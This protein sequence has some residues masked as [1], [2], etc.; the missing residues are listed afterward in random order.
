MIFSLKKLLILLF[1]LVSEYSLFSQTDTVKTIGV[2]INGTRIAWNY[3]S[4]NNISTKG[5]YVR[6]KRLSNNSLIAVYDDQLG[7]CAFKRSIDNGKT[8][9]SVR[10]LFTAYTQNNVNVGCANPEIYQL[11]NGELIAACNNRPSVD[12]VV[13][14]SISVRKSTDMGQTWSSIQTVFQGKMKLADA[15][16]E[17]TFLELPSGSLQLYFTDEGRFE[18]SS[19]QETKML[20]SND[21]GSTWLPEIKNVSYRYGARDGMPVAAVSEDEIFVSIESNKIWNLLRPN[22]LKTRISEPWP[23]QVSETAPER[24]EPDL[25]FPSGVRGAGPYILRIPTGEI[26]LSYQTNRNR[27]DM[28]HEVMEVAV[29]DKSASNFGKLTQPFNLPLTKSATWNSLMLWDSTTVAAVSSVD[30]SSSTVGAWYQLGHLINTKYLPTGTPV[31]D[32]QISINEWSKKPQL[33]IGSKTKSNLN[34]YMQGD[35]NKLYVCFDI[36]DDTLFAGSTSADGINIYLDPQNKCFTT[37][38]KNQY[39]ISCNINGKVDFYTGLNGNWVATQQNTISASVLRNN[40]N[41]GYVIEIAIPYQTIERNQSKTF[42]ISTELINYAAE[43]VGY[44]ESLI[45]AEN[46]KPATWYELSYYE[47]TPKSIYVSPTGDDE[48]GKGDFQHPYKTIAKAIETVSCDN[49]TVKLLPGIHQVF[50]TL[51]LKAFDQV[52]CGESALNTI[53]DFTGVANGIFVDKYSMSLKIKDITMRN[54]GSNYDPGGGLLWVNAGNKLFL[55]N[56]IIR[57]NSANNTGGALCF[58]GKKLSINNCWFDSNK[59][60]KK[61]FAYGGA[62]FI[63]GFDGITDVKIT[64][65]TFSNN[66][67]DVFGGA[68]TFWKTTGSTDNIEITNCTFFENKALDAANNWTSGAINFQSLLPSAINAKLVNNTFYNNTS[69]NGTTLTSLLAQGQKTYLTLVNNVITGKIENGTA[70]YVLDGSAGYTLGKNN[71]IKTIGPELTNQTFVTDLA[72]FNQF[73]TSNSYIS[74]IKLTDNL[75]FY[76]ATNAFLSPVVQPVTQSSTIDNGIF[77]YGIPTIVPQLDCWGKNINNKKDIGAVEFAGITA[78]NSASTLPYKIIA[79]NH[80]IIVNKNNYLVAN[81]TILD[82]VGRMVEKS[83]IAEQNTS[84][85]VSQKGVYIVLI[86]QMGKIFSQKIAVL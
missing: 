22:I 30:Y 65:S 79:S 85:V 77:E 60:N 43:G 64:N 16:W 54:A 59:V 29:G 1:I 47:N 13:P 26:L 63:Q 56:L 25:A 84:F 4:I 36:K 73:S 33:F 12:N 46:L 55:E 21:G 35:N 37:I 15:C 3:S 41:N 83:T 57:N 31:I 20:T 34:C 71:F 45:N 11:K 66:A 50:A 38:G 82:C 78:I 7:N 80:T 51:K 86:E 75:Q 67:S 48:N 81:I 53:I 18:A 49:D 2:P 44:T 40:S 70:L 69:G 39:K 8:W 9:S 52:I 23:L 14:Y 62:M 24:T 10:Y 61:S 6:M 42:R 76:S 5:W 72:N 28:Q 32:G 17:P 27:P 58:Y 19:F 74:G 68:I